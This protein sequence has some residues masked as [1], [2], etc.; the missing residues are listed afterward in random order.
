MQQGGCFNMASGNVRHVES[1]LLDLLEIE[2]MIKED[3]RL[4][5]LVARLHQLEREYLLAVDHMIL[6]E[7]AGALIKLSP[8]KLRALRPVGFA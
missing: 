4:P 7:E 6:Q 1:V 2:A 8:E 5:D 3:G